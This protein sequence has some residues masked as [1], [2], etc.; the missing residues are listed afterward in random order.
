VK[1]TSGDILPME[2][3]DVL[4]TSTSSA[5]VDD[6]GNVTHEEIEEDDV[7]DNIIDMIL[8]DDQDD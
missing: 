8:D 1:W 5:T 3:V 2:L 7:V 4:A 6:D